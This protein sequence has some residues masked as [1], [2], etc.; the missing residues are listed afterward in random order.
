MMKKIALV[1]TAAAVMSMSSVAFAD[2]A[3]PVVRQETVYTDPDPFIAGMTVTYNDEQG[4]EYRQTVVPKGNE[5]SAVVT[6]SDG[7]NT[8]VRNEA[9]GTV[10]VYDANGVVIAVYAC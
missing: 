7:I 4:N 8:F 5:M 9:A 10:T 3:N 2:E 1:L 6:W